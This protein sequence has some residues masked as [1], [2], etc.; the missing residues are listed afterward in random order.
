MPQVDLPANHG[1]NRRFRAILDHLGVNLAVPLADAKDDG[2]LPGSAASLALDPART[3]VA[4]VDL[5]M[6]SQR[7]LELA[8][9]GHA[10]TQAAEQSVD[11]VAVQARQLGDLDGRQIGRHVPHKPAE[12]GLGNS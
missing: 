6:A 12:N 9:L 8:R 10:L 7:S 5:D 3:K 4:L 1:K 11:G 2:L